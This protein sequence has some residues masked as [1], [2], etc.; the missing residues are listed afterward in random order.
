MEQI[1]INQIGY[2]LFAKKVAFC[3]RHINQFQVFRFNE[4]ADER[5]AQLVF[6]GK[7]KLGT[8][9]DPTSGDSVYE[10]DFSEVK[11]PGIYFLDGIDKDGI[12]IR[13]YIFRIDTQIYREVKNSILK[14]FYYQR[15]GIDLDQEY[16]AKWNH[17][18]CHKQKAFIYQTEQKVDVS[19]GWHD[20]GDYGRYIEPGAKAVADLLRAF[21]LFPNAYQ[22]S[23]NIP[24]SGNKVPDLLNEVRYEL[25]WFL[26]MQDR[27]T[28]GVY[29]KVTTAYFPGMIMPEE[30]VDDL[31]V[32]P[33]STTA[34][35]DFTAVMAIAARIYQD[36]DRDFSRTCLMA[37]TK[38]FKWLI[39][40]SNE[41]F[42]SFSGQGPKTGTG[43]Y[44]DRNDLDER[45]WAAAEL[46]RTTGDKVYNRYFVELYAKEFDKYEYSWGCVSGY[47]SFAYLCTN[48]A[49]VDPVIY[50]EIYDGFI[51]QADKLLKLSQENGYAIALAPKDY[52]W[53]SNGLLMD[54]AMHLLTADI[55]ANSSKYAETVAAHFHY[56]CGCNPLGICYIT[57]FGS[58]QVM[59][60]HHRPSVADGIK[61]SVPGM[62]AGGPNC[63]LQD[64]ISK[65][66][67][68]HTVS[69]LS[70]AKCFVD[71]QDS[72]TTNET[73][74]YWNSPAVLSAG[75]LDL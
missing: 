34:T 10:L 55:I 28:G 68:D 24:E 20:A 23:I 43:G 1:F 42:Y 18:G 11:T 8:K 26:K 59:H 48:Q 60:P 47:G 45:Y 27:N 63:Y 32:Y 19:G 57:G 46:L 21:E 12:K 58:K 9:S 56:L 33:F 74:I 72:Y 39:K 35:A 62:V 36:F 70:P 67:F 75:Y 7:A 40:H 3:S 6:T 51:K 50:Q 16:A 4:A 25:Q 66:S 17:R 71:H 52:V 29:A 69:I 64:K 37:A 5:T 31:I 41:Q 38:A 49:L 15:C 53:G 65:Q 30:D 2:R 14:S 54:R 22:A 13:S 44:G 61:Q 73:A